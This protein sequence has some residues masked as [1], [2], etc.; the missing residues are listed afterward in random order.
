[1]TPRAALGLAH[2]VARDVAAVPGIV[3]VIVGGSHARGDARPG[4]DVD[5]GLYY[6][7]SAGFDL[8]ALRA[9]AARLDPRPDAV[10]PTEPGGWGPRVGGSDASVAALESRLDVLA[11]LAADVRTLIALG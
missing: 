10:P 4:S 9:A 6:R 5:L 3:A 11:A 2:V 1:M 8:G 7:G